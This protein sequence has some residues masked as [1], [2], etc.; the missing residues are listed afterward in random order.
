MTPPSDSAFMNAITPTGDDGVVPIDSVIA[1]FDNVK[2]VNKI[3]QRTMAV[4]PAIE[5]PL[6]TGESQ[7]VERHVIRVISLCTLCDLCSFGCCI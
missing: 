2:K 1:W 5:R 7:R 4:I 3:K 6:V